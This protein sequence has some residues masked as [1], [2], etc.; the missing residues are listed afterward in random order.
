M[1]VS[2]QIG[3]VADTKQLEQSLQRIHSEIESAFTFRGNMSKEMAEAAISA[4]TLSNALS[5]ATM[6]SGQIS[7]TKFI[8]EINKAGSSVGQLTTN[9][10]LGGERFSASLA[11]ANQAIALSNRG[12]IVLGEKM[13]EVF[14]VT[15][16]SFKFTAA[17]T[18]LR[19]VS[20]EAQKA[21]GWV[22][23]LN[24]AVNN[25]GVVTGK[26]GDE[27][28]AITAQAI[29]ASKDLKV[30]AKEYAEGALIFYQ[31]GLSDGEVQTRTEVTIQAA[32]AA[33]Q[34][35]AEM[36]QQLTSIWNN[37]RMIGEEQQR[38]ASVGAALAAKTAVDFS[39]IATA[40]QSA[41]A[42]AAQMGVEY[43]Q[44]AAI[45]ATV[46]DV[47]QQ[48]ASTIG[49]AYKTIFSRFEQLKVEGTDGEVTL[50]K[51]SQQL[52]S[53]GIEIMDEAGNLKDL[54]DI[55]NYVGNNWDK[56]TETQQT[57]IAQVAG[58]AR[59][60][61][62][63]LQLFNNWDKYSKN[64]NIANAEDGSA[65]E[66]QYTQ[67]LDSIE[68]KAEQAGEAWKRAF[69]NLIPEDSLKMIYDLSKDFGDAVDFILKS[70]GGLPGILTMVGVALSNKIIPA[71]VK[72]ASTTK[73]FVN[74]LSSAG[75]EKNIRNN[76]NDQRKM[77]DTRLADPTISQDEK[78]SLTIQRQKLDL[79]ERAALKNE[80]I[81][82]KLKTATGVE[83]AML[84]A[85]QRRLQTAIEMEEASVNR[86]YS[87]QD[88]INLINDIISLRRQELELEREQLNDE[89]EILIQQRNALEDRVRN[90]QGD[91]DTA[92][93]RDQA[94]AQRA[95]DEVNQRLIETQTRMEALRAVADS[96]FVK[97][98]DAQAKNFRQL[99]SDIT[100]VETSTDAAQDKELQKRQLLDKYVRQY[101][102]GYTTQAKKA[103]ISEEE[104]N[105][106]I[107]E[108]K[109]SLKEVEGEQGLGGVISQLGQILNDARI[110]ND[111]MGQM[112][113]SLGESV[114]QRDTGN[115]IVSDPL[116]IVTPTVDT[117]QVI[118][119]VTQMGMSFTG[120]MSIVKNT[121]ATLSNPDI[122]GIEKFLT[123]LSQLPMI[124]MTVNQ[125][126]A[127]GNTIV[128]QREA[129]IATLTAQQ[130]L[131]TAATEGSVLAEH[132]E[133]EALAAN[134][135]AQLAAY[136]AAKNRGDSEAMAAAA[137]AL[138]TLG[139]NAETLAATETAGA[140]TA[141]GIAA[142]M[143][144]FESAA[145]FGAFLIIAAL[146]AAAIAAI[147]FAWKEH[148][149]QKPEKQLERATEAANEL[150][151]AESEAKDKADAL[152]SAFD[153]YKEA[154]KK[155]ENLTRGTEEWA[156]ALEEV[157]KAALAVVEALPSNVDVG[158]SYS[159]DKDG[160]IRL[161][162][163]VVEAGQKQLD[164]DAQRASYT[165]SA[166]SVQQSMA[167]NRL[168]ASNLSEKISD[169]QIDPA[170]GYADQYSGRIEEL[171]LNSAE[172]F[173]DLA[174][175]DTEGFREALKE[176]GIAVQNLS[177]S[178]IQS[179]ASQLISLGNSTEAA[180]EKMEL[181]AKLT[182][183]EI[184]G[185][186]NNYDND[187]KDATGERIANMTTDLT[188]K[189][190]GALTNGKYGSKDSEWSNKYGDIYQ[191]QN[192]IDSDL[193]A[194][195][196]RLTGQNLA[197]SGNGVQGT[198]SNRIFEFIDEQGNTIKKSAQ[199][200]AEEMAAAEALLNVEGAAADIAKD[201]GKLDEIIGSSSTVSGGSGDSAYSYDSSTAQG[202]KDILAGKGSMDSLTD[203]QLEDFA[204]KS[205]DEISQIMQSIFN[206]DETGLTEMLKGYGYESI[207]AFAEGVQSGVE[208]S[209]TASEH[210]ADKLN[211][212]TKKM[213]DQVGGDGDLT[214]GAK[215]KLASTLT[216]I[217][218]N[219]DRET[220]QGFT[221]ALDAMGD[222]ADTFLQNMDSIDWDTASPNVLKTKLEEMGIEAD[223]LSNEQLSNLIKSLQSVG[224][225]SLK[226]AEAFNADLKKAASGVDG[227]SS[228]ISDEDFEAL[229]QAGVD[230]DTFFQNMGDGTHM[231][232]EDADA[233]KQMIHDIE[234]GKLQESF[235]AAQDKIKDLH[236]AQI[237]QG[238]L[239]ESSQSG[240]TQN[241]T[242]DAS[243]MMNILD[244]TDSITNDQ[245]QDWLDRGGT[246]N[247]EVATEVRE[248]YAAAGIS[249]EKIDQMMA[250]AA[251]EAEAAQEAMDNAE[252]A[253]EVE[254]A[255]LDLD[256]TTRYA[257]RLEEQMRATAKEEGKSE[258]QMKL[259]SKAAK[260]AAIN[261]QKL[262]R[263]IGNLKSNLKDYKKAITDANKGTAEWSEA[264]DSL[265]GDLADIVG[266]DDPDL[267][268]DDFAEAALNGEDLEK[269]LD[270]DVDAIMRLQAAAADD[271]MINIVAN[272]SDDP[273]WIKSR[274]EQLKLDFEGMDLSSPDVDQTNLINSFNEMIAAGNMTKDQIEAALAGLHVS[275]NVK[276]TYVRQKQ[277]VPLTVTETTWLENGTIN[278][279]TFNAETGEQIG[280]Y[281][282]TSYKQITK[283]YDAGTDEADVVVP[284]YEIEGTEGAGGNT[285]AFTDAP[286]PTPSK[287]GSK[288]SDNGSKSGGGSGGG[289]GKTAEHKSQKADR[290]EKK[291]DRYSTLKAAI[292]QVGRA[293]EDF[294]AAEDDAFGAA[295]YSAMKKQ[296]KSLQKQASLYKE[297]RNLAKSYLDTDQKEA[298]HGDA[299]R[300][301][302]S[303]LK[304]RGFGDVNLLEAT[305]NKDG[306]V[307]NYT[308][309]LAE[310]NKYAEEVYNRY[311][312]E[313]KKFD[314]AESTDEE[315]QKRI[316]KLKEEY[317]ELSKAIEDYDAVLKQVDD[318]ADEARQAL[319]DE[320]DKIKEWMQKKV[321]Q[322]EWKMNLKISINDWD[323]KQMDFLINLWGDLGVVSGDTFKGLNA[324]LNSTQSNL[325]ATIATSERMWEILGNLDQEKTNADWF[326]DEFGEEAWNQYINGNGGLPDVVIEELENN[327]ESMMDYLQTMYDNAEEMLGQFIEAMNI[328]LEDFDRIADQLEH[329]NEKLEML[330]D[331]LDFSGKK[332]SVEGR[333]AMMGILKARVNTA[334]T[335]VANANARKAV[336]D[337]ALEEAQKS[338]EQFYEENG[339]DTQGYNDT[340]KF[341][342]NQLK[343]TF[344]EASDAASSAQSDF[345]SSMQELTSAAREAIEESARIIAEELTDALGGVFDSMDSGL[346]M[347]NH[348]QNIDEFFL[349]DYD[350][351]YELRKLL[352]SIDEA[353]EDVTDPERL[354]EW[355]TLVDDINKA[356][357][358]GVQITQTDL[359]ILQARFDL[360]KAYDEYTDARAGK[361]TMRLQRDASGNY[362]YVYSS[363]ASESDDS[364]QKIED[365]LANIHKMHRE[366][367]KEMES[368]WF[369]TYVEMQQYM[370]EV[371]QLRLQNDEKYA[372]E[373]Q[374]YKDMYQQ[375]LEHYR[376]QTIQHNQAIDR[377]YDETTLG[378]ITGMKDMESTHEWYMEQALQYDAKLEQSAL[379]WE[380]Q[381]RDT[382]NENGINY[383][384]LEKTVQEDTTK[385]IDENK[386]LRK[387]IE[388]LKTEG[389]RNLQALGGQIR[390]F[391]S[392][393]VSQLEQMRQKVFDL[394]AALQELKRQQLAQA[395]KEEEWASYGYDAQRDYSASIINRTAELKAQGYSDDKIME[396]YYIQRWT[397]ERWN[398]QTDSK[399]EGHGMYRENLSTDD[400]LAA[401]EAMVK[402]TEAL[403]ENTQKISESDNSEKSAEV[404]NQNS[405]FEHG[406]DYSKN[407][408]KTASGGLI[409]T[410]QVRSLAEEGPELVLNAEDTQK[411]LE[412]VRLVRLQTQQ[413][414]AFRDM[415]SQIAAAAQQASISEAQA[416]WEATRQE[417]L[418]QQVH[419]EANFPGVSV[420]AEIED[421]FNQL[422]TQAAQYRIRTDR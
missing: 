370:S 76:Y 175:N 306:F 264:M 224:D 286:A 77:S 272:Q 193:M 143:F 223:N 407:E 78:Q 321:D 195:Y 357:E 420:A 16:Q 35:V 364:E 384:N 147:V 361:N 397:A 139:L 279:P 344:D 377:S 400:A 302:T 37:Y 290:Y 123:V 118:S 80:E 319:L 68:A 24:A 326:K 418:D 316:E 129:A 398:K 17:Q 383:D 379:E 270:G 327:A 203:A 93:S 170:T 49:N 105:A 329:N 291:E 408:Y 225:T 85:Q 376:D 373:V 133:N 211:S 414:L 151:K 199:Q 421:A 18:F 280:S 56:W 243:R 146:V 81:N 230:V 362:S 42:P 374:W 183:D 132:M 363:D 288:F 262:D 350:K 209:Q 13:K 248:A 107:E 387:E 368:M 31:Q 180:R 130:I 64:L 289:G 10:A 245:K 228:I 220:A 233:F 187:T 335:A 144:G 292:N 293:I 65:L 111:E 417:T 354:A 202:I 86:I 125:A 145:A 386:A 281:P 356:N 104:I 27:M 227:N 416:A 212:V 283:T 178:E 314:E 174:E 348:Q 82:T 210:A 191:A 59:Q 358:D 163:D 149:N 4:K 74:S 150:A 339:R 171:L 12:A 345:Y 126:M 60:Y 333:D 11:A 69:S 168:D 41:A 99:L 44:L 190:L 252:F 340:Q 334:Q 221:D 247:A 255:G 138:S 73:E 36:S 14:R 267:L 219:F 217:F 154:E 268:T 32:K 47:S 51:V 399:M 367:A 131:S 402:N 250:D 28:K 229:R 365:A 325:E 277:Q 96:V 22:T 141:A 15:T 124:L 194:D 46:G 234:M 33:G 109:N 98:A 155:L 385:M 338:L 115:K 97:F 21:V 2:F 114:S 6:E 142:K 253:F 19:A 404:K 116:P 275:A 312:D 196:N 127:A 152:A 54:G 102:A 390:S 66:A 263:G 238:Y 122:S 235:V 184:L 349:D 29:Q 258:A 84:E 63:L 353:M 214:V 395:E 401:T 251:K 216:D 299:K 342:Y 347:Y 185:D 246:S 304:K 57:A 205:S 172:K 249:S 351:G 177:D 337:V 332:Y 94:A 8:G 241:A 167:K 75:R 226:A 165:A 213:F 5:K 222:D 38:A 403:K 259:L 269:A 232:T 276:T 169:A 352:R 257:K 375:K 285:V 173:K 106:Q 394:I 148:E 207:E 110:I 300:D 153:A 88:E 34:S 301:L 25:I 322:A 92:R 135:T 91:T 70:F 140:L 381:V 101:F 244:Y 372:A 89:Q 117:T 318:T 157:N 72:G 391:V 7:Y 265:K 201:F 26:S 52:Q 40:M 53:L 206:V 313:A 392:Q 412:A 159:R 30:A 282:K 406:V 166:A 71:L 261:N 298:V 239:D 378:V 411:I 254:S 366:A 231:L 55:I 43:N 119:G 215:E 355:G 346:D 371:D 236:L 39:D 336:A 158:D 295:K 413:A 9:L 242:L 128:V 103:E 100:A 382:C 315:W 273:E 162:E 415:Q 422:V 95:L 156:A 240:V 303:V 331:L 197:S 308:E 179:F 287:G 389:I 271:M 324:N 328:I 309:I 58:G 323:I 186:N 307:S 192:K 113:D 204:G 396:D 200:M 176:A 137:S 380:Q 296:E 67:A 305:F 237:S 50:S 108:W 278:V 317:E 79:L 189:Y 369:Q 218:N 360:Q 23:D 409:T 45:I 87:L 297:L 294:S 310:L 160:R 48:S 256:E 188:D 198:D 410:P 419:I 136:I 112:S 90:P 181:I 208:A 393:G 266:F 120:L 1:A 388:T 341:F 121:W 405:E 83:K 20:S 274:W 3:F 330:E 61:G 359:E 182:V 62:L 343:Q 161:N 284:Q 311:Y 164:K 134:I 320:L 260:D